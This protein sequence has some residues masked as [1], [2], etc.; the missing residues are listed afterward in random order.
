LSPALNPPTASAD[1]PAAD[2]LLASHRVIERGLGSPAAAAGAAPP[3][4]A[5]RDAPVL[6]VRPPEGWP[7]L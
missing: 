4:L 3:G 6:R 2:S 5:T 7:E 1:R